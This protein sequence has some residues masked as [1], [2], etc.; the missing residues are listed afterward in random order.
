MVSN[1]IQ[2]LYFCH[3]CSSRHISF[4]FCF[5]YIS[6]LDISSVKF[7]TSSN[8]I[9]FNVSDSSNLSNGSS[10]QYNIFDFKFINKI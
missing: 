2:K 7:E 5:R 8:V 3:T 6:K 9:E 1:N 10:L 4:Y